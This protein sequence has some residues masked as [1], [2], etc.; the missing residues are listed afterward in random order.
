MNLLSDLAF[1]F[2]KTFDT[3]VFPIPK[4]VTRE[5]HA[6]VKSLRDPTQ[7]MS[8]S[9]PSEK[10]RIEIT[11]SRE[12]IFLK[13]CRKAVSD[14]LGVVT[15]DHNLRPAVS[16]LLDLYAAVTGVDAPSLS[17]KNWTTLQLKENLAEEVDRL[18][19]PI[20]DRFQGLEATDEI[21]KLLE[22][23]GET[24]R[25]I[26]ENNMLVC[27][28]NV[29]PSKSPINQAGYRTNVTKGLADEKRRGPPKKSHPT[30]R[31]TRPALL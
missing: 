5:V 9:A 24:A 22:K 28:P 30:D 20:R 3:D 16:S 29:K 25:E 4:Q 13:K 1:A 26:A 14:N 7:K 12:A 17:S 18:L 23:N 15:Y 19:T 2:N 21:D 6:R 31:E 8:K 27:L 10:S 11:D